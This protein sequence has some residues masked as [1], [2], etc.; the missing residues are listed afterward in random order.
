MRVLFTT[1]N[2][3]GL[4]YCMIPLG[5][6]MQAAGHDV[7]FAC[8]PTQTATIEQAGITPVQI[9]EP[10]GVV[11]LERLARYA[12]AAQAP[13]TFTD[14]VP[15]L[16]PITGQPVADVA[17]YDI[18]AEEP[19]FREESRHIIGRNYRSAVEFARAWRP[20][21]IIHDLMTPEGVL[22][23]AVTGVPS[24][25]HSLGMFG[26][27]ETSLYDPTDAFAAYGIKLDRSLVRYVIDPTPSMIMPAH[28]DAL[29][30]P[31]RYEPYNG[32][33]A[34]PLWVLDKPDRPRVTL[35]WSRGTANIFGSQIPALRHAIEAATSEGAEV[36]VTAPA[37][38][39]E[40]LTDLPDS[41]RVLREFPLRML[42]PTSSALIHQGSGNPM[43]SGA[44]AG[45]PQLI[46]AMTDDGFEM[47]RR[48]SLAGSTLVKSGLLATPGQIRDNVSQLLHNSELQ[49]AAKAIQADMASNPTAAQ[50]VAPLE[51]LADKGQITAGELSHLVNGR[52]VPGGRDVPVSGKPGEL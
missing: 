22:A 6:A 23:A 39:A 21:L 30:L 11:E 24:V 8:A 1:T 15:L 29:R 34:M 14:D 46:L 20:D 43:M 36:V 40:T 2:W 10:V 4:Y 35:V 44:A 41:V 28:G 48:F 9:F 37:A 17:D 51:H 3:R 7:R 13:E 27:A 42:L 5:W 49:N 38:Q 19:R 26:A 33:G 52:A 32:P 45:V 31:I 16:H 12:A 18:A 25:Y 47:G 50:L